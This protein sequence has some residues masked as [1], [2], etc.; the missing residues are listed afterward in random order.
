MTTTVLTTLNPISQAWHALL[1]RV[2][3]MGPDARERILDEVSAE[4]QVDGRLLGRQWSRWNVRQELIRS[5]R[6]KGKED[7]F[8]TLAVRLIAQHPDAQDMLRD[9]IDTV[10][11]I[12]YEL[13]V[14]DAY[15]ANQT[16]TQ[17][18]QSA[19]KELADYLQITPLLPDVGFTRLGYYA[20]I[21]YSMIL[22]GWGNRTKT[23]VDRKFQ[24]L[25]DSWAVKDL[26]AIEENIWNLQAIL[27]G[28]SLTTSMTMG[29]LVD[30]VRAAGFNPRGAI[31]FR[32]WAYDLIAQRILGEGWLDRVHQLEAKN[33]RSEEEERYLDYWRRLQDRPALWWILRARHLDLQVAC[34]AW[35]RRGRTL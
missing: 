25:R 31:G 1:H 13:A 22:D 29:I 5:V 14:Q 34:D 23:E 9:I 21:S 28:R 15:L 7:A 3:G 12:I 20:A 18:H 2:R 26:D 30:E 6:E 33:L 17:E 8:E 24:A 35:V 10:A 19:L 11:P 27:E 16:L 32:L 4:F